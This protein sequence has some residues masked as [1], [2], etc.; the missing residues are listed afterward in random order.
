[1]TDIS[2]NNLMNIITD[3]LIHTLNENLVGIYLHGSAAFGCFNPDKS[4]VDFI[5]VT[6][7]EPDFDQKRK[8]ISFLLKS[9][10]R[11]PQKGWR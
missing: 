11:L 1:M 5:V 9:T 6:E 10:V 2:V 8:I 4:D 7:T 3:K